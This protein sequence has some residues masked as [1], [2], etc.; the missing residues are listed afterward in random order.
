MYR[1]VAVVALA[2]PS[3]LPIIPDVVTAHLGEVG[4]VLA[5]DLK[6]LDL[7]AVAALIP[8][9]LACTRE[10]LAAADTLVVT[11]S[12]TWEGFVVGLPETP[13]WACIRK[14]APQLGA[15]ARGG[16]GDAYVVEL[17]GTKIQLAWHDRIATIAEL[18]H[19]ARSGPPPGVI[20]DLAAQVPHS[21]RGWIVSSGFAV[22]KINSMVAW[23]E[24]SPQAWTFIV[25]AEA[26]E[27]G[28]VQPWLEGIVR[29][30]KAAASAKGV[31]VDDKWFAITANATK[32]K[33]VASVPIEAF[34]KAAK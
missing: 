23:L 4:F 1:W 8:D 28:A 31:A 26:S 2:A 29:G 5:V 14:L 22:Q 20:G 9:E 11:A 25:E 6:D 19:V 33:L 3:Q 7:G 34:G 17:A 16:S 27:V 15:T 32:G 13:T 18:G 12:D 24:T 30:F 21:A 10:L